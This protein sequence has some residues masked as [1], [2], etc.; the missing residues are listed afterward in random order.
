MSHNACGT[1]IWTCCKNGLK[2]VPACGDCRGLSCNN[3]QCGNCMGLSC[4]NL[5]VEILSSH[6]SEEEECSNIFEIL[7]IYLILSKM[8]SYYVPLNVM[9]CYYVVI[10]RR[11]IK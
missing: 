1:M 11:N 3:L 9:I 7:G 4:N 2:C 10:L 6:E 8:V 5:Q